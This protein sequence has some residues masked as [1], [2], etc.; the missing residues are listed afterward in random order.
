MSRSRRMFS[1]HSGL[2]GF[3]P[4]YIAQVKQKYGIARAGVLQ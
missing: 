3:S 1:E 4:L 2:K